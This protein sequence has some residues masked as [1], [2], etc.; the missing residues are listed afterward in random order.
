MNE[1]N[2]VK[3]YVQF[4]STKLG[5]KILEQETRLVNKKLTGN[6]KVLSIGCGP[7]L[8]EERLHQLH[9]NMNIIALDNSKEMIK[10][11]SKKISIIYGDA[12]H[13]EFKNSSFDAVLYVASLEFIKSVQKT[14]KETY[15]VL[16]SKGLLLVLMLN[17]NSKYFQERYNNYNSYIRKN[18]KHTNINNIQ[19]IISQY[20][21]IKN[22]GY[23]LGITEQNI[24]ET[25]D[26]SIAS[27]FV[28]EGKKL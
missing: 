7:A 27:L 26:Q 8:I 2:E 24:I 9:P 13:L 3:K 17:P 11:A 5:K 19:K 18:I 14:I 1:E 28:L 10:C 22:K 16:K 23:Y 12:Q 20:F 4:Y 25:S 6:K 15:R 21:N